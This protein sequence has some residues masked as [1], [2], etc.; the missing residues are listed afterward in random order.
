MYSVYVGKCLLNAFIESLSVYS[1]ETVPKYHKT[2]QDNQGD[3]ILHFIQLSPNIWLCFTYTKR[4]AALFKNQG[5]CASLGTADAWHL[6][7]ELA[8]KNKSLLYHTTMTRQLTIRRSKTLRLST[9]NS[10][11][12]IL[13]FS[14]SQIPDRGAGWLSVFLPVA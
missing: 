7:R 3:F 2:K 14:R 12:P 10:S 13:A 8:K 5:C 1:C 11:C 4:S 9:R 6:Q